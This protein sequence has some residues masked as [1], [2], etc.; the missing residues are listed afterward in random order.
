MTL[1]VLL[2]GNNTGLD[3]FA[4]EI[5]T[6][7][8][9][10]TDSCEER[11]A[12]VALGDVV[13]ELH[14]DDG[15]ADASATESAHLAALGEG[16]DQIDDLDAGLQNL[17]LGILIDKRRGAAVDRENLV[18][19]DGTAFVGR[20]TQHIEDATE[21]PLPDGNGDRATEA[22]DGHAALEALGGGHGDGTHPVLA[23]VLLD[24]EG[25]LG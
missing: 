8:G 17:G 19:L 1:L 2:D 23:E 15:L 9:T 25:H 21:N 7:T 22:T 13:D 3:H 18:G 5:V 16:T 24:L 10:L 11:V 12:A 14:D 4:V 6:L 20:L